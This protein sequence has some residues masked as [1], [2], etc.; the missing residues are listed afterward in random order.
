MFSLV[1]SSLNVSASHLLGGEIFWKCKTNGAY[2]F[3][4]VLYRDCGGITLPTSAQTLICSNGDSITCNYI[5][6][7]DVTTSCY[8]GPTSCAGS[9][10]GQGNMQ[11]YLYQSADITLLGSPP[12]AGW[13]FSWTDCCRPTSIANITGSGSQSFWLR[14]KMY[15]YTPPGANAPLEAGTNNGP[16]CYDS[17]PN[18]LEDPKVVT[19]SNL[20]ATYNNLGFDPDLDSLYYVWAS[21]LGASGAPVSWSSGFNDTNQLPSSGGSTAAALSSEEGFITFNSTSAGSF[22]TCIGVEAWRCNQKIAEV[23]RDIPI[24]IRSCTPPT[25]LCSSMNQLSEPDLFII[26]DSLVYNTTPVQ[27]LTHTN[28]DTIGY[29]AEGYPGDTIRILMKAFD[30]YPNPNCMSKEITF[31]ASGGNLSSA[32]NY[33]IDTLCLFSPPCATITSLNPN[34]SFVYTGINEVLFNWLLDTSHLVFSS[35]SCQNSNGAEYE[36]YIKMTNDQ[37][38][39]PLTSYAKIIVKVLGSTLAAPLSPELHCGLIDTNNQLQLNWTPNQDTGSSWEYYR[40]GR[41]SQS[42]ALISSDTLTNWSDSSFA[43]LNA[44]AIQNDRFFIQTKGGLGFLSQKFY[45]S[46]EKITDTSFNS[47]D[48]VVVNGITY[49][50]SGTFIQT[51]TTSSGCD[52]IFRINATVGNTSFAGQPENDTVAIGLTA[53]FKVDSVFGNNYQWQT[54]I[55]F[56]FVNITNAGQFQGVNTPTLKVQSVTQSNNFSHYRC[57]KTESTCSDTSNIATL[58]V[59]TIGIREDSFK[60]FLFPNPTKER[61]KI[62]SNI[63]L[64]GITVY[65]SVGQQV[66]SSSKES[67]SYSVDCIDWPRGAYY[68]MVYPNNESMPLELVLLD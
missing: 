66:Y 53:V 64:N 4:L 55:G 3:T 35:Q 13:T 9:I 44:N 39:V 28:G 68:I 43:F 32:A 16:S 27:L 54:D 26:N 22:A 65:N 42:G 6:T 46:T 47:C 37:C 40:I 18:F 20:D 56:G 8:L 11:K 61:F 57:V 41:E 29:T 30:I 7:T 31:S 23:F 67:D 25:G 52:S 38:P 45:F 50:S 58:Y 24:V 5:S 59:N 15:P 33:N 62:Q 34:N 12:S 36:F 19:C 1:I 49:D 60:V 63:I 17:S 2:Q 51:F 14:A 10:S 21:P 48:S